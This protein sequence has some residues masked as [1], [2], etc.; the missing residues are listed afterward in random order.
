[1]QEP[2][3]RFG[4]RVDVLELKVVMSAIAPD[5]A[6]HAGGAGVAEVERVVATPW[7]L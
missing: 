1:M 6:M 5:P 7:P 2:R 3:T 4:P